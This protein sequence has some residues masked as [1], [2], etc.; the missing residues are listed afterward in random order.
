[1]KQGNTGLK[2]EE[3]LINYIN[4]KQYIKNMNNNIKSFLTNLFDFDLENHLI[5]AYKFADNYKPDIIIT[6]N[7]I[8][9]Y[10]SIKTGKSNSVHQEH[11]YSFIH[12]LSELGINKSILDKIKLFHFNDGSLNGSG[13]SRKSANDFQTSNQPFIQ[14]INREMNEKE[15]AKKLIDRILFKGEYYHLPIVDYI[16][17]GDINKGV[18][19]SKN[20]ILNFLTTTKINS[21][22]IHTSKLYY[23]ALHRNLKYDKYYEYRRYYVQFKWYSIEEDLNCIASKR[24]KA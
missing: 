8:S 1:M 2:N 10:I 11:L 7:G 4:K 15:N 19:A 16:Y 23:Q 24:K 21:C 20:E 5:K 22:A 13:H 9:K 3:E 14:E 6:A 12:F 18:Y 17:Y